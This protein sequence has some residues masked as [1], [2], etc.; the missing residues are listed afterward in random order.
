MAEIKTIE[1]IFSAA[2]EQAAVVSGE[3]V[4]VIDAAGPVYV[5]PD[6]VGAWVELEKAL[7]IR[8]REGFGSVRVRSDV[9]QS[10][11][12]M[13]GSGDVVDARTVLSGGT[14]VQIEG[15][16]SIAH[17]AVAVSD[18]PVQV[19]P[20]SLSRVSLLLQCITGPVWIGKDAAVTVNNG[21]RL[22]A[23]QSVT[24]AARAAVWAVALAAGCEVR[25]LEEIN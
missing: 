21:I 10:V 15:G 4:H 9:A 6:G 11:R 5:Q 19:V 8:V 16:D 25:Y 12:L 23:G 17:G 24:L 14:A 7:G 1:L 20:S 13:I 18:V 2:G 3:L 22:D